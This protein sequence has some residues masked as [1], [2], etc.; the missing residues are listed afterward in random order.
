M[1][2]FLVSIMCEVC[3]RLGTRLQTFIRNSSYCLQHKQYI[4]ISIFR[5]SSIMI[6]VGVCLSIIVDLLNQASRVHGSEG[7]MEQTSRGFISIVCLQQLICLIRLAIS[8]FPPS[9]RHKD[10]TH[11]RTHT[12]AHTRTHITPTRAQQK[13]AHLV[14]SL[15]YFLLYT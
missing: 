15:Y 5:T 8:S 1:D 11:T 12:H 7:T 2:L 13:R 4:Y 9:Y 3:M 14:G 10:N 6:I